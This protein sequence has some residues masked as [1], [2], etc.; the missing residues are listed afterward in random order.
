LLAAFSKLRDVPTRATRD[1]V[2]LAAQTSMRPV[3]SPHLEYK[4]D[5]LSED[6]MAAASSRPPAFNIAAVASVAGLRDSRGHV[7]LDFCVPERTAVALP[8]ELKPEVIRV[9][10][11]VDGRRSLTEI[12]V[13]VELSLPE[14]IEDFFQLLALGLVRVVGETPQ[15]APSVVA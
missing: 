3:S 8:I 2:M 10:G 5:A 6:E 13:D 11:Q 12:A 4:Y 7:P 15:A 1:G 9:L 14:T